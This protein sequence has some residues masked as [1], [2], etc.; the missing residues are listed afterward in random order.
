MRGIKRRRGRRRKMKRRCIVKTDKGRSRRRWS[1]MSFP[2]I[3]THTHMHAHTHDY[4]T[5][6]T[7]VLHKLDVNTASRTRPVY[8]VSKPA[9]PFF[10]PAP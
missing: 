2:H 4:C 1:R 9:P 8:T 10:Q 5:V 3:H 7:T 6:V